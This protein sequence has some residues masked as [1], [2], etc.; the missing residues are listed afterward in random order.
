MTNADEG[1][2]SVGKGTDNS[3]RDPAPKQ[4][5]SRNPSPPGQ[6]VWLTSLFIV[7]I[8]LL[9]QAFFL[10]PLLASHGTMNCFPN[11]LRSHVKGQR[12]TQSYCSFVS[13]L[14]FAVCSLLLVNMPVLSPSLIA[15]GSTGA[16][17]APVKSALHN[18]YKPLPGGA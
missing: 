14:A 18:R 5:C 16:I 8:L 7:L 6:G 3:C 9:N 11:A 15:R 2:H 4:C 17:K 13:P 12:H 10:P 1:S